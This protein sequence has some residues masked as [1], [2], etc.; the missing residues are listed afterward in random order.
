[1]QNSHG[2]LEV[3]V[4]RVVGELQAQLSAIA[5][6]TAVL[7]ES[8]SLIGGS[9]KHALE[10]IERSI[11]V[12]RRVITDA[13]DLKAI[14]AGRLMFERRPTDLRIAV[15]S[16][17][18]RIELPERMQISTRASRPI[19]VVADEARMVRAV[20]AL[21]RSALTARSPVTVR[22]DRRVDAAVVSV[23]VVGALDARSSLAALCVDS[24]P[25]PDWDADQLGLYVA[26][27]TIEAHGGLVGVE[28]LHDIGLRLHLELPLSQ[29]S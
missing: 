14:E 28:Q 9:A 7:Q 25:R 5:V 29:S 6:E 17:V 26:R 16:A 19:Q 20:E 4:G 24:E 8:S 2:W 1:M 23:L 21:L 27:H 13:L 3:D 18:E 15:A 10:G 22:I 11:G 12:M